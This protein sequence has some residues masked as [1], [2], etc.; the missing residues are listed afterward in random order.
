MQ[1]QTLVAALQQNKDTLPGTMR[2][3]GDSIVINQCDTYG[4]YELESPGLS[5][6][7]FDCAERG[8]GLN[9]NT[10][11]LRA[12][13]DVVLFSDED[14]VYEPGY[15]QKVTDAFAREKDAD[16]FIFNIEVTEERRTYYTTERKQVHLWNCGRYPSYS[17]A[18][19]LESLRR[20]NI[21]YSLLFGGG[22]RYSNGEDSLFIQ[23]CI[24]KGLKVMALPIS[25]GREEPR[26]STWFN[27]YNEKF[28][29]DRGVLYKYMYGALAYPMAVRFLVKHRSTMLK[30]ISL[31]EALSLMK[32]GIKEA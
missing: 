11:L 5:V 7:W 23:E 27:G 25:I 4:Y 30:D 14:I 6:R 10:A 2:L 9:R 31:G 18:C 16:I 24:R 19:R 26:P 28:F 13:A 22:A 20:K 15:S 17:F 21:T 1:L 12:D 32:K 29:I 3:E 8:V